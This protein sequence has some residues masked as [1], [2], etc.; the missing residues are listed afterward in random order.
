VTVLTIVV[1]AAMI[2]AYWS[3]SAIPAEMTEFSIS[4]R[5]IRVKDKLYDWYEFTRWWMTEK[6]GHKLLALESPGQ[7]AG[8]LVLPLG[9]GIKEEKV[10]EIMEKLLLRETPPET[11]L[12]KMGK[13]LTENFP[14]EKRI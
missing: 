3:W 5:G 8:R 9:E 6:W 1:V 14:L 11:T 2:F 12:D 4:S 10:E 7:V 13:W